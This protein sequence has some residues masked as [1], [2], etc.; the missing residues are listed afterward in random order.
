MPG[1]S[2]DAFERTKR[3][4][5]FIEQN[6]R[7]L[8]ARTQSGL[9]IPFIPR[10]FKNDSGETISKFGLV[11]PSSFSVEHSLEYIVTVGKPNTTFSPIYYVNGS[12]AVANG[13]YGEFQI[14]PLFILAY[15]T[16]TPAYGEFFGAKPSQFTASKNYPHNFRC[17]GIID[18]TEKWMAAEFTGHIESLIGKPNADI[19]KGAS[20]TF[21]IYSGTAGSEAIIT[22]MTVSVFAKGQAM[23][24]DNFATAGI[25]NGQWYGFPYECPA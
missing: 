14:G 17:L 22:S 5:K 16:G 20:G 2:D 1:L 23:D 15:D 8:M 19:A 25:I 4:V 6:Q 13:D 3:A 10:T 24:S 11:R 18:A 7:A 21:N 9:Q 12:E